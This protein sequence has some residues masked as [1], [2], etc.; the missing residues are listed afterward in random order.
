MFFF[1]LF[2]THLPYILVGIIYF[3]TFAFASLQAMK[4]GVL[5]EQHEEQSNEISVQPQSSGFADV[6]FFDETPQDCSEPIEPSGLLKL[7]PT[8][9]IEFFTGTEP[10]NSSYLSGQLFVR[11]PP[12][13]A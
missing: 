4:A 12:V 6:F 11:P 3:A 10:P 1:G 5:E 7:P 13:L 9:V 2:S 8:T